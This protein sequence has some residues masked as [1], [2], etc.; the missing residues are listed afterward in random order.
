MC[1]APLVT[2]M[3]M[4]DSRW[5]CG[6]KERSA[7]ARDLGRMSGRRLSFCFLLHSLGCVLHSYFQ[8]QAFRPP[9]LK[10]CISQLRPN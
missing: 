6:G 5:T 7:Q 1:N 10:L 9:R 3:A 4:R 8:P 2:L